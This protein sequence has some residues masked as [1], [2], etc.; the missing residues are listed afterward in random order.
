MFFTFDDVVRL[1]KIFKRMPCETSEELR[2]W[3][4]SEP[5]ILPPYSVK[6]YMSDVAGGFCSTNRIAYLR[7]VAKAQEKPSV[8]LTVGAFIHTIYH[9]A[10]R[11]A[12]AIIYERGNTLSG[13]GFREEF[14]RLGDIALARLSERYR[15]LKPELRA[16]IFHSLWNYA[17]NTYA[18]ALDR[19][20]SRSPYMSVDGLATMVVPMTVEY[21]VDGSLIGLSR[22]LRIDAVLLPTILVELKTRAVRHEHEVALAGYALAFES[23][24]EVPV[25][26]AL[27]VN[28]R[29]DRSWRDFKIYEHI[30][31][32]SDALRDEFLERRDKVMRIVEEGI[33]PGLP[34]RCDPNCPYIGVCRG[35]GVDVGCAE[36]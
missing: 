15:E 23:Q 28:L 4:W 31:R 34:R 14:S 21:P 6:L 13:A 2:G 24:Y 5:P 19:F 17:A 18:S 9:E 32:I 3:N 7:H 16:S 20:K 30:V 26:Y 12:K 27:I 1:S 35:R 29:F 11:A 10:S 22:T 25:D 33:D 8:R 36:E